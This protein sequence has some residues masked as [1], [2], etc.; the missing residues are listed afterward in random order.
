MCLLPHKPATTNLQTAHVLQQLVRAS[1]LIFAVYWCF[2]VRS[3]GDWLGMNAEDGCSGTGIVSR[4]IQYRSGRAGWYKECEPQSWN[5][6]W[7][8]CWITLTQVVLRAVLLLVQN[9]GDDTV[10]VV[11]SKPELSTR[12]S[13]GPSPVSRVVFPPSRDFHHLCGVAWRP[14]WFPVLLSTPRHR[15][16]PLLQRQKRVLRGCFCLHLAIYKVWILQQCLPRHWNQ[17]NC[18]ESG[19]EPLGSSHRNQ[20]PFWVGDK[21]QINVPS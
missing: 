17:W 11:N 1:G 7:M 21:L 10:W 15:N 2:Q 8:T 16:K 12:G 9:T 14:G 6:F 13:A 19:I 3:I 4:G 18:A 5:Q 20:G